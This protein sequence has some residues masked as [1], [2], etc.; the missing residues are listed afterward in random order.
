MYQGVLCRADNSGYR[1]M[2]D[3]DGASYWASRADEFV[4][5]KGEHVMGCSPVLRTK[6]A[7]LMTRSCGWEARGNVPEILDLPFSQVF[8]VFGAA[9]VASGHSIYRVALVVIGCL[10][11]VL[12]T[13]C[14]PVTRNSMNSTAAGRIDDRRPVSNT[15]LVARL[16]S[17]YGISNGA[18]IVYCCLRILLEAPQQTLSLFPVC[19]KS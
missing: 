3:V 18:F 2:K 12:R 13:F 10:A 5:D 4:E 9:Q 1:T 17:Y 7:S 6:E 11:R 16:L 8:G 19:G 14:F 15:S